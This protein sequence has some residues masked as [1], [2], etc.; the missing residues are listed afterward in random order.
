[1]E[2]LRVALLSLEG[3]GA[4]YLA[5]I[6]SDDHF[7]LV[8]VADTNLE[9]IRRHAPT[10]SERVYADYRS[11]IVEMART[12]LDLLFVAAEPFQSVE[13][14]EMAGSR[15]IGVF[16]K[17]PFARTTREAQRLVDRFG[18]HDCPLAVCRPWQFQPAF[19][20]FIHAEH[21]GGRVNAVIAEVRT[22]EGSGGWRGD[23]GRAGGG[24][25]LNGAYEAVDMLVCMLGL[26]ETVYARCGSS[27]GAGGARNYDTEDVSV[28][29][30]GF[31]GG[32]VGSVAAWRGAPEP[33][34]RVILI[35]SD[36]TVEMSAGGL[37][38]P[39]C[40][41]GGPAGHGA[42]PTANP[43]AAAISSFG[44]EHLSRDRK[45]T[46]TAGE[47]LATMAVIEA[48]Y[49]AAKTGAAESPLRFL[50]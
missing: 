3:A 13:F 14:V 24:V 20:P 30:L 4:D 27:V 18:E 2:R 41:G 7:D 17:A 25:L 29:S 43:T 47:H 5:A 26:P 9:V 28:L 19:L 35:G 39:S 40:A 37:A 1:M 33:V 38:V 49:L 15:G 8:A 10:G 22:T 44:E 12:G 16:H 36:Q 21:P 46:S 48:A 34:W 32:Q 31:G 42:A 50:S 11:L 45:L 6:R 23:S